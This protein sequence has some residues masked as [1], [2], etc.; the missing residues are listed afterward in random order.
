MSSNDPPELLEVGRIVRVHGL[1]GEVVV[2]L[3]SN[4][5]ERLAK[6]AQLFT[7]P[8][9]ASS[10]TIVS[11]KPHQGRWLVRLDGVGDRNAAEAVGRP[12]LYGAPVD[13]PDA[14]WLHELFG[15]VV[16]DTDGVLRGTVA[17]VLDN[18]ASELMVLDTGH[19]VPID[20][21]TEVADGRITVEVPEGLWEL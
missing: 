5:E 1:R 20:F 2:D 14:I 3:T 19:L 4:V 10:I 16:V 13:D 15:A 6:G 8:D 11:A 7:D 9:G 18:P 21:V 12:R 17:E